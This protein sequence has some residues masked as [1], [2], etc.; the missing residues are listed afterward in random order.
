MNKDE[1]LKIYSACLPYGLEFLS[2]KDNGRYLL[3]DVKTVSEYPLWASTEWNDETLKYEPEINLKPSGGIGHGFSFEEVK[4]IFY[5]LS[6]LTKEIEHEGEI[7]NP[8]DI[9]IKMDIGAELFSDEGLLHHT[10]DLPY[11]CI[12]KLLE[13]HFNIFSLPESE[14]INKATLTQKQ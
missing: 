2:S 4:P 7:I 10:L 3:T 9:L 14:Y 8:K 13:W 6:C 5:D 11:K 1:L 12:Q